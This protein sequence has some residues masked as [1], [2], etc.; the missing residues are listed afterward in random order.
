[1]PEPTS[2]TGDATLPD[3]AV[4]KLVAKLQ[5]HQ[6]AC[7]QQG[8]RIPVEIYLER[9]PIL[10][11]HPEGLLDLI[12]QEVLLSEECGEPRQ[13]EDYL[14]RFPQLA[15]PLRAQFEVHEALEGEELKPFAATQ[16]SSGDSVGS[17][18]LRAEPIERLNIPGYEMLG[19]L[20]HGGMG[21]VYWVW[22]TN[23]NRMAALKMV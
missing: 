23:L 6:R 13:L 17:D 7:W 21:I 2:T 1:M 3:D 10:R 11:T 18:S 19:V 14:R 5:L 15:A 12:Y 20:G 22:Q 9:Y 4:S 16:L 8:D